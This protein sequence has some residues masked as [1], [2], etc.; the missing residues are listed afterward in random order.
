MHRPGSKYILIIVDY[1]SR[2][3]FARPTREATMKST[4]DMILNNVVPITRRPRSIY[5]DNG[6]RSTGMEIQDMFARFGVTH[7]AAVISHLSA[8]GLAERYVQMLVGQIRLRCLDHKSSSFWGLLV[9]EAVVDINTRCVRIH[10]FTPAE[11]LL[12]YN[13]RQTRVEADGD[14]QHWLKDGLSPGYVLHPTENQITFYIDKKDEK[15]TA[16]TDRVARDQI[17]ERKSST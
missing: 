2:F 17:F 4:M 3:L 7:F 6:R 9:R 14:A 11:I 8:A 1:Y 13:P 10:G 12:G 15:G 16:A 5:S